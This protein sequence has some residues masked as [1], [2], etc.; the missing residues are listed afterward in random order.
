MR[1]GRLMPFSHTHNIGASDQ[2][3]T[4][5]LWPDKPSLYRLSYEGVEDRAGSDPAR[6]GGRGLYH[7]EIFTRS[8]IIAG[9]ISATTPDGVGYRSMFEYP[10]GWPMG[11]KPIMTG[12]TSQRVNHFATATPV[13]TRGWCP[14]TELNCCCLVENRVS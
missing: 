5:Y 7:Y 9:A 8:R 11:F 10:Q 12:A 13:G 2:Y 4:G 6:R 1:I 14:I 3:R